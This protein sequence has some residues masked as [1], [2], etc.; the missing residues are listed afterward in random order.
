MPLKSPFLTLIG[1]SDKT[2]CHTQ[3]A[4]NVWAEVMWPRTTIS[5]TL[6]YTTG[7]DVVTFQFL[8]PFVLMSPSKRRAGSK[9]LDSTRLGI[10]QDTI[11]S[12]SK[13]VVK[14]TLSLFLFPS[15][16]A[17]RLN[18]SL[19]PSPNPMMKKRRQSRSESKVCP[20]PTPTSTGCIVISRET[21]ALIEL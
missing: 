19:N 15:N 9:H 3:R 5:G 7:A 1:L 18:L 8:A 10:H 20:A 16:E 13:R 17:T 6:T 2:S 14:M 12:N 4:V 21:T 11:A